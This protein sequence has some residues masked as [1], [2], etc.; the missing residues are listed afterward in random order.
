MTGAARAETV[1]IATYNTE[2]SRDGP[3]LL[4]RDIAGGK[5]PQ[6]LAVLDVLLSVRADIVYLQGIDY[7]LEGRALAALA[8]ALTEQGLS[9]PHRF[10]APPNAGRM[11]M[12][13]LDG[14][15]KTGGPGDAQGYGRFFGQGA[16]A[17]LSRYPVGQDDV[18]DFTDL[19]WRDL[20]GAMMPGTPDDPFPSAEAHA[21]QRLSTHGHWVVPIMHPDV[22]TIHLMTYHAS[23]PVF[24]GPEDRNGRRNHDETLFWLH[25][26][27]GHFGRPPAEKFTLIGDANLDPV[28]G[29]GR[30]IAMQRLLADPRLQDPQP[31][32]AT[33]NWPQTGP[34]RVDYVLPSSDWTVRDA[35]MTA[36]AP[37][38][39]RHRLVWVDLAR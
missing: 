9:Y 20:P 6:V 38:A 33:V 32:L 11:T 36:P 14:D 12:E 29:D 8:E 18:Q 25:Y 19:L 23:P 15:G 5:D 21:I 1:R 28:L 31:D 34:M 22:G 24:D 35:G 37:A 3:G 10:A 7:D 27:D 4:L 16:P 26:L 13:D 30:G 2:L 17:I 39:S